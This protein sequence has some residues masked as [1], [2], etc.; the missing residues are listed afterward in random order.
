MQ[1]SSC[2]LQDLQLTGFRRLV[3]PAI[4]CI[5]ELKTLRHLNINGSNLSC[6]GF[7]GLIAAIEKP[8]KLKTLR[9]SSGPFIESEDLD[10]GEPKYNGAV[11]ERIVHALQHQNSCLEVIDIGDSLEL[12]DRFAPFTTINWAGRRMLS[13]SQDVPVGIWP[14]VFARVQKNSYHAQ[15]GALLTHKH[16]TNAVYHL[17][18]NNSQMV[19]LGACGR[20]RNWSKIVVTTVNSPER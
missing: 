8:C 14:H 9:M 18:R 11:V 2:S 16:M 17:L 20:K 12:R 4:H 15:Q 1:N 5:G 13:D 6:N 19:L 10:S 3:D 7:E